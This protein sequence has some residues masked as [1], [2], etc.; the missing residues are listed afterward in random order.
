MA[1]TKGNRKTKLLQTED[2][3]AIWLGLL[4]IVISMAGL[5]TGS[6]IVKDFAVTPGKW[7]DPAGMAKDFQTKLGGYLA[8]FFGFLVVFSVIN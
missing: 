7:G 8:I 6:S 1:E 4:V 2:Y 3:W 5:W